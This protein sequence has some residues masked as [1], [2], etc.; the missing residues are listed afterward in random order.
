MKKLSLEQME[1]V[2]GGMSARSATGLICG[3]SFALCCSAI[4]L[5]LGLGIS[6]ACATAVLATY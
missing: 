3:I 6:P 5:P 2:E 1:V 4:F